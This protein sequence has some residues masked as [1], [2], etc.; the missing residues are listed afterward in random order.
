M[1]VSSS[2]QLWSLSGGQG[3]LLTSMHTCNELHSQ[4]EMVASPS[5][6]EQIVSQMSSMLSLYPQ[7]PRPS[8]YPL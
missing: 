3:S 4:V 2:R 6:P 5:L 8:Q 1:H 7:L